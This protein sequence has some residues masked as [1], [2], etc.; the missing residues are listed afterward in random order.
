MSLQFVAVGANRIANA[1]DYCDKS[2]LIAYGAGRAIALWTPGGSLHSTSKGHEKQV[3]AVKFASDSILLSGGEDG[4][5]K[6]W[7]VSGRKL[8]CLQTYGVGSSVTC[9]TVAGSTVI[10]GHMDGNVILWELKNDKLIEKDKFKV[11]PRFYPMCTALCA[12]TDDTTLLA[13]G[14]TANTIFMFTVSD[15]K[16]ELRTTLEGHENWLKSLQFRK[17]DTDGE[18]MLASGSLDRYIRIW[19]IHNDRSMVENAEKDESDILDA[20]ED[21]ELQNKIYPI[22]G[23]YSITFE[24]L[25]M[26]HDDW[27]VKLQW[28]PT[29]LQLISSSADSSAMCWKPDPSSGVWICSARLGDVSVKGS[30]TAT[31][32][33]GGFWSLII[34]NGGRTIA[35]S[36]R[37]GSW[38]LWNFDEASEQWES[39]VGISGHVKESTDCSW[40]DAGEY[41]LT[42]SLDQTTRLWAQELETGVYHEMARPQIHG[43]DMVAVQSLDSRSF[44]SAGDEK[45]VRVFEEPKGV[46][47]M[48]ARLSGAK[49]QQEGEVLPGSASVP[50]LGLSNKEQ[51]ASEDAEGTGEDQ[52]ERVINAGHNLSFNHLTTTELLDMLQDPPKEDHL[53][54][55]TLFPELEKLYGHGYEISSIALTHDKKVLATCCKANNETHAVIR[56]YDTAT[57]HQIEPVCEKSHSLTITRLSFSPDD[58][59][60]LSV[61]RDRKCTLWKRGDDLKHYSKVFENPKAHSRIIW[62]GAW[63]DNTRFATAARDKTVKIWSVQNPETPVAQLSFPLPVT[64]ID[65]AVCNDSISIIAGL[66]NGDL[67]I[68]QYVDNTF[69]VRQQIPVD[70]TPDKRVTRISCFSPQAKIAVTSEDASLRIYQL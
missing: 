26:G 56:L 22:H 17:N 10:S 67:Y 5:L 7:E 40:Q 52:E 27:V 34:A 39:Q 14:G 2:N 30:S 51:T 28:H 50:A 47:N 42:T 11:G 68:C 9:V 25:L 44:V 29:E 1:S 37:T 49:A 66:E 41:L 70:D 23:S 57:W 45:T 32:S 24:A 61:S 35:T 4:L 15:S 18:L 63:I 48:L 64:A 69:T 59:Y 8:K 36:S 12:I 65:S 58:N 3:S 21:E 19:K 6:I 16:L 38:R 43:Y 55:H 62:D 60:L 54:R 13:V 33:S 31:G 46:A 20:G 53:Q